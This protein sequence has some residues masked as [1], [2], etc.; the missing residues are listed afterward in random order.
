[1]T[2]ALGEGRKGVHKSR[3]KAQ[4]QLIYVCDEGGGGKKYQNLVDVI[5][6]SPPTERIL[7]FQ[8]CSSLIET[9]APISN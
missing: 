4:E 8:G 3:R 7:R 2:S 5:S 1:M 9:E 6:A